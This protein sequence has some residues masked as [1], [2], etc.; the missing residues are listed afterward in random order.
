MYR[1]RTSSMSFLPPFL[2]PFF[3]PYLSPFFLSFLP[4]FPPSSLPLA[5]F[6][7]S[8]QC[9][10]VNSTSFTPI[11]LISLSLHTLPP[12]FQHPS[13]QKKKKSCESCSVSQSRKMCNLLNRYKI[14][15]FSLFL[16]YYR[17]TNIYLAFIFYQLL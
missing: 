9:F 2:R 6:I 11:R 12:P 15:S 5:L 17:M 13:Q 7:F 3:P 10:L 1:I 16:K 4:Y 8:L 14:I